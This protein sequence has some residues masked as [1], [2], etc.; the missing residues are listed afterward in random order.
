MG[1]PQFYSLEEAAAKLGMTEE[2]V[3]N[4]TRDGKLREFRD[5]GQLFF[6]TD[7]VDK[8]VGDPGASGDAISLEDSTI[9]SLPLSDEGS[10][11]DSAVGAS[12]AGDS[13]LSDSS[14]SESVLS[15]SGIAESALGDSA[16]G[17]SH[18]GTAASTPAKDAEEPA[19]GSYDLA[20][21]SSIGM[22]GTDLQLEP[23][24]DEGK[25]EEADEIGL[26]GTDEISLDSL[27]D[28][29]KAGGKEDTVITSVG[30]SV[31]D[32]DEIEIDVD[33]LAKTRISPSVEDQISLEG[34]GSGS[35]LLDLTRESDDTS[36]G[37]ELLD[38]I[39]PGEEEST[40][41][42]DMPTEVVP[43]MAGAAV[44]GGPGFAPGGAQP[45]AMAMP[46]APDPAAAGFTG[47]MVVGLIMLALT[48]TIL[49]AAVQGVV[50]SFL[51]TLYAQWIILVGGAVALAVAVL[52][53]GWLVGKS[54]M[55]GKTP[56]RKAAAEKAA[57]ED[58]EDAEAAEASGSDV[59]G[60]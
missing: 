24:S 7:E 28:V 19:L 50:P 30:I 57:P 2:E 49:T 26:S 56:S 44:A 27:D 15:D 6:K 53:I 45:W 32:D 42:E 20:E 1:A 22:S 21:D 23:T 55:S 9:D 16:I 3:K 35:G 46:T 41:Q 59:E 58:E 38:E 52:L 5:R 12:S 40:V 47:M 10:T 11:D 25:P 29:E 34:V 36:L 13:A 4:L 17:A 48:G 8:L 54:K 51:G 31:F 18:A 14:L 33:P 60:E 39:Y 43:G 37:A